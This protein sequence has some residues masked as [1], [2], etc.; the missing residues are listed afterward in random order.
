MTVDL[1]ILRC[2]DHGNVQA[3][4]HDASKALGRTLLLECLY[5]FFLTETGGAIPWVPW[6]SSGLLRAV[7]LRVVRVEDD[8]S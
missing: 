8:R 5:C 3:I 7:E 2:P 4:S 6:D 1:E